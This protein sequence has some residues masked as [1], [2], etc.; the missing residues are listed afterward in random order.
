M[1][2][3]PHVTSYLDASSPSGPSNYYER[4]DFRNFRARYRDESSQLAPGVR[5]E[6]RN[7]LSPMRSTN[8]D[9]SGNSRRWSGLPPGTPG[10]SGKRVSKS[11]AHHHRQ[12]AANGNVLEPLAQV[13]PRAPDTSPD[14]ACYQPTGY[15]GLAPPAPYA[16]GTNGKGKSAGPA[17]R[18]E[19]TTSYAQ[20]RF[21]SSSLSEQISVLELPLSMTTASVG[22]KGR[23][24][25]LPARLDTAASRSERS[26]SSLTFVTGVSGQASGSGASSG[27][28]EEGEGERQGGEGDCVDDD[29][30][31]V[32]S[33]CTT[34][35]TLHHPV[36][37]PRQSSHLHSNL[38]L[39]NHANSSTPTPTTTTSTTTSTTTPTI[40]PPSTRRSS[41]R[42]IPSLHH[43]RALSATSQLASSTAPPEPETHSESTDSTPV[44][45]GTATA[46]AVTMTTGTAANAVTAAGPGP[47]TARVLHI[48]RALEVRGCEGA[49]T[50]RVVRVEDEGEGGA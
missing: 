48:Q 43:L 18:S 10:L 23:T 50:I 13:V 16:P 9:A 41:L 36:S 25:L 32:S 17:T 14:V 30:A 42:R 39:H 6:Y 24:P 1:A 33:A 34:H 37:L 3:F 35:T 7:P 46:T 4:A 28:E 21:S 27:G 29:G 31:S 20:S 5:D 40:Q 44:Q 8:R 11:P 47:G 15:P 22:G 38:S 49:P 2:S 19:R 26:S 12:A 45:T